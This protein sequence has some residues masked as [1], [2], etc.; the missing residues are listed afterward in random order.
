MSPSAAHGN[1]KVYGEAGIDELYGGA[2]DDYIDAGGDTDLAFG[3][4]GND[5]MFGGDGPDELRGGEGDDMLSGGSGSDKLKG[6]HGDDIFFGGIGQA[7][8][9]GDSDEALGDTGFDMA[10]FSDASIVLDTAADLRNVN[11][12]G[13]ARRHGLRAVQPTL[14][15]P[16]GRCWLEI[17]RH[18]H[19]R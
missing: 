11:L 14:D 8:Q 1:D 10:A 16:R 3:D 9:T 19:R 7:A 12:T 15:R 5:I 18:H 17:R 4:C 6:E 13:S 2:G